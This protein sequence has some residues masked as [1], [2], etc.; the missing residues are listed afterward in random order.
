MSN[1]PKFLVAS[2]IYHVVVTTT[3]LMNEQGWRLGCVLQNRVI[4]IICTADARET[5]LL[6]NIYARSGIYP[7]SCVLVRTAA[8][9]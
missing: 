3:I 6:Q 4:G 2:G 1:D 9:P 5:L 8:A 7:D